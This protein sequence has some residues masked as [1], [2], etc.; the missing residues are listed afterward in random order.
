LANAEAV[1]LK[2]DIAQRIKKFLNTE[3]KDKIIIFEL[4]KTKTMEK[5]LGVIRHV[6]TFVGGILVSQGLLSEGLT[7]EIIGGVIT[8]AG[9]VWSIVAK[10]KK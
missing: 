7:S 1:K 5:T 8:I 6:L 10:F 9:T 4:Q 2:K 3:D